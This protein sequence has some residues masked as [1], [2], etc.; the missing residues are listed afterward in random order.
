MR[1]I[2]LVSFCVCTDCH[3]PLSSKFTFPLM[4]LV[5][6]NLSLIW[7]FFIF[8]SNKVFS[9]QLYELN[10]FP[11]K[12]LQTQVQKDCCIYK[13]T[14]SCWMRLSGTLVLGLLMEITEV[15]KEKSRRKGLWN[16]KITKISLLKLWSK[17]I[18][19]PIWW[20]DSHIIIIQPFQG[21]NLVFPTGN[22]NLPSH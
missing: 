6:N 8:L 2:C 18:I 7:F 17:N 4:N 12:L 9:L 21:T 16:P 10:R 13:S 19:M 22:S 11:T 15:K 14:Y 5:T 1:Q 3:F 20:S